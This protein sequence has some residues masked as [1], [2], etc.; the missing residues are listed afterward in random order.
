MF[1]KRRR[2]WV[3]VGVLGFVGIVLAL[4][5]FYRPVS[6]I[7]TYHM[8]RIQPGM[9]RAQVESILGGPPGDYRTPPLRLPD[10]QMLAQLPA[11][12][13]WQGD[14]Y[15]IYITFDAQGRVEN[16]TGFMPGAMRESW[17]RAL[18]QWLPLPD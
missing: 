11:G 10:D 6:R 8:A 12:E 17:Y 5:L 13:Q 16:V 7:S 2:L 18:Q 14:R 4:L 9:T 3:V 1:K 15:S